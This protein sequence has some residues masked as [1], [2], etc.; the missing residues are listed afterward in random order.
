MQSFAKRETAC[1]R[2]SLVATGRRRSEASSSAVYTQ[3]QYHHQRA[4]HSVQVEG[5]N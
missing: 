1:Y 2:T 3:E 5:E 4:N